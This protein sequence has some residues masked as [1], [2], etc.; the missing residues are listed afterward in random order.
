MMDGATGDQDVLLA[1]AKAFYFA[2][3]FQPFDTAAVTCA[4][5][6]IPFKCEMRMF[7]R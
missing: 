1:M 2:S 3:S 4:F 7:C 6:G 5:L